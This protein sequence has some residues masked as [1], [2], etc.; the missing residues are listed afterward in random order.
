MGTQMDPETDT[1]S[2]PK[3]LRKKLLLLAE[4]VAVAVL[5]L[6]GAGLTLTLLGFDLW[7]MSHNTRILCLYMWVDA[8]LTLLLVRVLLAVRREKLQSPGGFG[9]GFMAEVVW[10]LVTVPILF[11][12]VVAASLCFQWFWPEMVTLENPL[13]SLLKR[14]EDMLL[15]LLTGIYVGGFK[16]EI[17]R[18]FVLARFEKLLNMNWPGLLIWSLYFGVGHLGQGPDNAFK[19]GLLGVLFGLL[20]LWRRRLTAPIVAHAVYNFSTIWLYWLNFGL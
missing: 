7:Q 11:L 6:L 17:Q 19:A 18:A 2:P 1:L 8:T 3:P 14:R 16:E 10:G 9:R 20:Y 4:I 15:F 5:G 12:M 13:L